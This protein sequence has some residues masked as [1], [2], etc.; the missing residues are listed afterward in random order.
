MQTD[1][2]MTVAYDGTHFNGWQAQGKSELRTVQEEMELAAEKIFG[3]K[4]K[5]TASGR[6]DAGVHALG[7]TCSFSVDTAIPADRVA[8][9]FNGQLPQDIRCLHSTM[10]DIVLD[11]CRAAKKKTYVYSVYFAEKDNPLLERYA[12][13]CKF[14]IENDL[15]EQALKAV[16]GEHDFKAFCAA[17]S[18]VKTTVRTVYSFRAVREK[19]LFGEVL[20]FYITGNGFL[21]NM[22]RTLVGTVLEV[23]SGK[24]PFAY[25]KEAIE[26]GE[27]E[28][29]GRTMPA[30]GL[31]LYSVEYTD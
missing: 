4:V 27:R 28:K 24:K 12:V 30:K 8:D 17:N 1:I 25:L 16:E 7:Q 11:A 2:L 3:Q 15:L 13:R 23:A 19:T 10:S 5:I 29:A 6:T 21:Y 31:C 18:Q 14:K 9:C 22:V 20:R 26:G